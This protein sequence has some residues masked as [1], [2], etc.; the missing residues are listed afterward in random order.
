MNLRILG[1]AGGYPGAG[2]PTS[3]YLLS[4]SG[5]NILI[6]CGSGVLAE[7]QR[8]IP[9]E[10][11]DM[12]ILTHL[13]S[14]HVSD[15]QVLRYALDMNAKHGRNIRPIPVYSPQTPRSAFDILPKEAYLPLTVIDNSMTLRFADT[16]IS[17]HPTAHSAEC[18]GIRVENNGAI[19][20][21]SSDSVYNESLFD[22]MKY[23]DL[24]VLDCGGLLKDGDNEKKHMNP[25][26]C[27]ELY[28]KF[29]VKRVVLS[30]LIPY[31]S[32]SDTMSEASAM[33]PWTWELAET[34]RIY[35]IES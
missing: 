24:A 29:G 32:V 1:Y 11:I 18:Y 30:H 6:D 21:Y 19:F 5:K 35:I 12:I 22:F 27:F 17:F 8:Y 26:D 13:H 9:I 7:I 34:D 33:G 23:A 25:A 2:I 10:C 28:K 20:S 14:D 3:G 31:H 15:M 4:F 16:V